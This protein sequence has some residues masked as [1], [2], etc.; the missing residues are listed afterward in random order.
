[1]DVLLAIPARD[2]S[3]PENP[4]IKIHSVAIQETPA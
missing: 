3:R 4:G 1:M 2:P